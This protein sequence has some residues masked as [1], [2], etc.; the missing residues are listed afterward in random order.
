MNIIFYTTK[1]IS[2]HASMRVW[3]VDFLGDIFKEWACNNCSGSEQ[4]TK[5]AFHPCIT[6]LFYW[7]MPVPPKL[8][9]FFA[10][11]L[12]RYCDHLTGV[13]VNLSFRISSFCLQTQHH[14]NIQKGPVFQTYVAGPFETS[15]HYEY[16]SPAKSSNFSLHYDLKIPKP[17][18][19]AAQINRN[20]THD[21][22]LIL[23]VKFIWRWAPFNHSAHDGGRTMLSW[24]SSN[25]YVVFGILFT[26][27]A[28]N[29]LRVE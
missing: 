28:T 9:D 27:D 11:L 12:H 21:E 18:F 20:L 23:Y 7:W 16:Q 6:A 10:R 8:S 26:R 2:Q 22:I 13:S 1:C 17:P 5:W 4:Q 14:H 25:M 15:V 24:D 3:F 29:R 19:S